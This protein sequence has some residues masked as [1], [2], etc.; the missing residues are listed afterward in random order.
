MILQGEILW[1]NL[2]EEEILWFYNLIGLD[3]AHLNYICRYFEEGM[4]IEYLEFNRF[5]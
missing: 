5:L 4:D 2:S 1:K 3:K